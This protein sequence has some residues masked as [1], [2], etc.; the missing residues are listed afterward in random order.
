MRFGDSAEEDAL[1]NTG[2]EVADVFVA[3]ERRHGI[4]IGFVRIAKGCSHGFAFGEISFV[5]VIPRAAATG[6]SGAG[7]NCG[8]EEFGW[9][10]EVG[11]E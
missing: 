10:L 1:G 11:F 7:L 2:D 4:A 3:D 5:G 6:D 8:V 9:D